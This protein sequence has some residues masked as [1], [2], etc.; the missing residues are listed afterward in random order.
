M[1]WCASTLRPPSK[2][3]AQVERIAIYLYRVERAWAQDARWGEAEGPVRKDY[4]S[5]AWAVA[6]M[7]NF[8]QPHRR[9]GP[10]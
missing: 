7:C 10:A 5:R 9:F 1:N 3:D 8:P 6:G 4:L 2:W